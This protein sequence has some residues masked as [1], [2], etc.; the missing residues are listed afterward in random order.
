MP[1][2]SA[3]K[4]PSVPDE[5]TLLGVAR[6]GVIGVRIVEPREIPTTIQR[7]SRYRIP[8]IRNQLPQLLRGAG[9]PRISTAHPD[10]RDRLVETH[11]FTGRRSAR[12]TRAR[13][14]TLHLH[15]QK[16][17]DRVTARVIEHQRRGQPQTRGSRQA[18]AQLHRAQRVEPLVF[19]GPL[20]I[21]RRERIVPQH[22][23]HLGAHN[24]QHH[25]LPLALRNAR[26][27]A[28]QRAP[29]AAAPVGWARTSPLNRG[30]QHADARLG[31]QASHL[32]MRRHQARSPGV[33]GAVEQSEALPRGERRETL[34]RHPRTVRLAHSSRHAARLL[35][36][37]PRERLP[38]KPTRHAHLRQR[39]QERVGGHIV[40]LSRAAEQTDR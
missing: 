38:G 21:D 33:P 20:R 18:S 27:S 19:Q 1:K 26:Q 22:R 2:K 28:R 36:Q 12:D 6:P 40:T 7:K 13:V 8:A 14:G 39:I 10:D 3:S 34:A 4:S 23:S 30:A 11:T 37:P 24:L 5:P 9:A 29:F 16:S 32:Q 25:P 15:P 31:A 35:P 17:G